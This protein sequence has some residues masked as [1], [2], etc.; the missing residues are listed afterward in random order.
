MTRN[1]TPSEE[2]KKESVVSEKATAVP[3]GEK[4]A[5]V[6][7]K[8]AGTDQK[9]SAA[10]E[11]NPAAAVQGGRASTAGDRKNPAQKDGEYIVVAQVRSGIR[12]P[13]DQKDTLHSLGLGRVGAS[14][15]LPAHASVLGM[16]KKVSH[17]V[18]LVKE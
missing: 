4:S 6:E 9:K 8:T 2:N 15:R 3:A 12:R 1:T 7:R 18:R 17:L 10:A 11:K 16:V 13:K 14:K 5:G